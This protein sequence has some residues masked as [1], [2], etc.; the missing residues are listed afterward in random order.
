MLESIDLLE[1]SLQCPVLIEHH[2]CRRIDEE[3][4]L[5][6]E[7]DTFHPS[8]LDAEYEPPKMENKLS[9]T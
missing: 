2:P 9:H 4:A 8:P 7:A 5:L 6:R 3:L 1:S